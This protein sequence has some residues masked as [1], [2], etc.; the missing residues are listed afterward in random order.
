MFKDK[1]YTKA[2]LKLGKEFTGH[3]VKITN[4]SD[5]SY[6]VIANTAKKELAIVPYQRGMEKAMNDNKE[7]TIEMHQKRIGFQPAKIT[8]KSIELTQ[9]KGKSKGIER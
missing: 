6:A 9:E 8:I 4:L 7:L 5:G 1:E 2:E 3:V